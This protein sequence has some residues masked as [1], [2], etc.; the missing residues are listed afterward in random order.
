MPTSLERASAFICPPVQMLISSGNTFTDTTRS[1][2]GNYLAVKWLGLGASTARGPRSIPARRTK[3]LQAMRHGQEEEKNL[4]KKEKRNGVL[5]A[6]LASL[7]A[8]N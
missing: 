4:R 3:I 1:V 8:D 5:P 7:S 2:F 6:L